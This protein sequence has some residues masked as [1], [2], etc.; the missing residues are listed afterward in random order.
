MSLSVHSDQLTQL[1]VSLQQIARQL[2]AQHPARAAAVRKIVL[3]A[4][5]QPAD[6]APWADFD[7]PV[8][9]SYGRKLVYKA[10]NFEIMV[11]SWRP[12]DFSTIHDHGHTQWG[13]VQIFGPAEHATFR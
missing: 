3:E 2:A 8:S 7:H 1:P 6:L 9:D 4:Q 10:D 13:A 11:M 12:G 5:V